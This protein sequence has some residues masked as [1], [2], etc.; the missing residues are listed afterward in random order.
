[1]Y[2]GAPFDASG[3]SLTGSVSVYTEVSLNNW[4]LLDKFRPSDSQAGDR[5]GVS[6]DVD[7]TTIFA[8]GSSVSLSPQVFICYR[9]GNANFLCHLTLFL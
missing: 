2:V 8:V 7:N 3:G 1:M 5:F 4:E 6:L 9:A